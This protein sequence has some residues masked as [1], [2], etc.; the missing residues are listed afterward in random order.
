MIQS[1][2]TVYYA[3]GNVDAME[4]TAKLV[5][6]TIGAACLTLALGGA[7]LFGGGIANATGNSK[8]SDGKVSTNP[9][10]M[11][12]SAS[13]SEHIRTTGNQGT[14]ASADQ[15]TNLS[16]VKVDCVTQSAVATP[17]VKAAA[18]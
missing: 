3:S 17:Q 13:A 11:E 12:I 1:I 5:K 18:K 4:N 7:G 6:K 14:V 9:P 15:C 16:S 10:V 2:L 8:D